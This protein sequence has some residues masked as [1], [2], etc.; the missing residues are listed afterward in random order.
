MEI[1]VRVATIL[2]KK[3]EPPL[4]STRFS[5]SLE[6]G[7]DVEGLIGTLGLPPQLVGSVT[8]N[9]RRSPRDRVLADGDLVAIVPAISGG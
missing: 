7:T 4:P 2:L 3:A 6:D 8:L 1:D 5:L 9:N